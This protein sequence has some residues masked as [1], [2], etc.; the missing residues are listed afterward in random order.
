M[1]TDVFFIN[2]SIPFIFHV[3]SSVASEKK[4]TIPV[5]AVADRRNNPFLTSSL[6]VFSC[7]PVLI[8][9]S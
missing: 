3:G 2:A 5:Y 4:K 8:R 7:A 6:P 9:K 1:Q